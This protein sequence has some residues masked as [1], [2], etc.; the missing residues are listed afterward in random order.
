MWQLVFSSRPILLMKMAY[1]CGKEKP[2]N[3]VLSIP[4]RLTNVSQLRCTIANITFTNKFAER[5]GDIDGT[6][7]VP[8]FLSLHGRT[9]ARLSITDIQPRRVVPALVASTTILFVDSLILLLLL[10]TSIHLAIA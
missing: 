5:S 1:G 3:F 9:V 2:E 10:P 6:I 7:Q 4:R 8:T